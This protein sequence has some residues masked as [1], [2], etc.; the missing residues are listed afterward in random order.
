MAMSQSRYTFPRSR[1]I[2]SQ[3]DFVQ[4]TRRGTRLTR[5]PLI[6]NAAICGTG[7]PRLGIR[8]SRRCGNAAV[9]NRVKRLLREAFRLSQH[10]WPIAVDLVVT[11]KPH[12]P[13]ALAEYQKLL[14]GAMV[15]L[16]NDLRV[17]GS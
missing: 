15:R 17:S 7:T 9:R 12:E 8:I 10:D 3:L 1:R 13:L 5:G 11:V 4:I 14:S 2:K 6:F 16:V